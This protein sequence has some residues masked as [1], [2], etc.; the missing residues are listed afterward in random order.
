MRRAL[1]AGGLAVGVLVLGGAPVRAVDRG[2]I[3]KAVTRGV[4]ALRVLQR[5]D[6]TWPHQEI[7]A[8]ALAGLTLLECD[9]EPSDKAVE[10]AADV[11][12]RASITL[13]HTY[14]VSLSILFLDR[15]G[16]A[17]DIPLIESMAV[18][19]LAGQNSTGGWSYTCPAISAE[20]QRRLNAVLGQRRELAARRTVPRVGEPKRTKR[21]LAPE[22]QR[23]L[24]QLQNFGAAPAQQPAF[25]AGGDNSNTQFATLALWVSR[26]YGLPVDN[27]LARVDA[28]FRASQNPDGGWSYMVGRGPPMPAMV[29]GSLATMTCAGLLGLAVGQGVA[30]EIAKEQEEHKKDKDRGGK[31]HSPVKERDPTKDPNLRSGLVALSGSI[32]HAIGGEDGRLPTGVD[33]QRA[34]GRSF[35]FLWSLERVAVALNLETIGKKDWYAWGSEVLLANQEA[36]GTWR[37]D[38]AASGVDTCFALL[39]LRRA[40]LARDLSANLKGRT[41]GL[42]RVELRGGADFDPK[43][44]AKGIKLSGG[45]D[46]A[47][48]PPGRDDPDARAPTREPARK[49]PSATRPPAERPTP[50]GTAP[51]AQ[52]GLPR[53]SER[54]ASSQVGLA[55]ELVKAPA[56]RQGEVLQRLRDGRGVQFTDALASAIPQLDGEAKRKAREALAERLSNFKS[57]TVV[58]YLEDE[59][60]EVRRAAALAVA[61]KDARSFAPR[62]VPLLKDRD[63]SVAR[64]AHAALK[65]MAGKDLGTD[66]S[67]WESW[68]KRQGR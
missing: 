12:R 33:V 9:V 1:W 51:A 65:A 34:R 13:Q 55:D 52:G 54:G 19:L 16:D 49:G 47:N 15:L 50:E 23:Q 31:R 32:G 59:D 6:G 38:Y 64:A 20:E 42:G 60:A 46:Q 2:A 66:P 7:G 18:R 5:D 26:R 8:T 22:I 35:Y 4:E 44:V 39:F 40:N 37:G 62:V 61:M 28:R 68:A 63:P 25:V 45:I 29:T 36:D 11:V 58:Q 17:G 53:P 48:S 14:S 27:A 21:D 43:Q 67:A 3:E 57:E 24:A 10:S 41:E 56:A 30:T